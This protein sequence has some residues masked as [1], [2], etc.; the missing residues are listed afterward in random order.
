MKL[1]DAGSNDVIALKNLWRS[2]MLE[3]HHGNAPC[4]QDA[5]FWGTRL[6]SQI[7]RKQAVVA[8]DGQHIQGFAGFIDRADRPWVPPAVAFLVDLYVSPAFRGK[9]IGVALLRHIMER[10]A[11]NGCAKVW[12]NTEESNQPAQR[13][14]E[15]AGFGTLT[16]FELPRLKHQK[17]YQIELE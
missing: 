16:G 14:L 6:Q 11:R 9:A 15:R 1:R 7:G 3:L 10:A 2:F 17:Y 12:T 4:T 5:E 13:C 8:D